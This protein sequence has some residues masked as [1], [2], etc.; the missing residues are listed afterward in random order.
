MQL[1]VVITV[2]A[3]LAAVTTVGYGSWRSSITKAQVESDLKM[4]I[5]TMENYRNFNNSYSDAALSDITLSEGNQIAT[6]FYDDNTGYCAQITNIKTGIRKS[7]EQTGAISDGPCIQPGFALDITDTEIIDAVNSFPVGCGN[8]NS[9]NNSVYVACQGGLN[10]GII[11][12]QSNDFTISTWIKYDA[13]TMG[14][15]T[16][17]TFGIPFINKSSM[18]I[19]LKLY[20]SR[21]ATGKQ[22]VGATVKTNSASLRTPL[23][24]VDG[25]Q[26]LENSKWYY[27]TLVAKYS[28]FSN[29]TL[30][31]IY[32][33]GVLSSSG[34]ASGYYSD[35]SFPI[36]LGSYAGSYTFVG[37]FSLFSFYKY[38][39]SS[40]EVADSFNASRAN[41]GY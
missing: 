41:Y 15:Y 18:V 10:T 37:D 7:T 23:S 2:I 9:I 38:A 19:D 26:K 13:A 25:S 28:G 39:L 14:S 32:V 4:V 27:L 11:A 22:Y 29:S 8:I 17:Y 5:S 6:N 16:G 31:S 3:I 30:V 34:S 35:N 40:T 36:S 33:N 21:T 12:T 1:V 24:G 20:N